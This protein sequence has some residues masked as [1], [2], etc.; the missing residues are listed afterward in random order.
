MIAIASQ[1]QQYLVDVQ[2]NTF[3][4]L[5]L[6]SYIASKNKPKDRE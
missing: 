2:K 1:V 3:N 6:Q 5:M 4:L